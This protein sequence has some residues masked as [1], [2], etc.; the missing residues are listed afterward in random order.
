VL[1][2][3]SIYH[4]LAHRSEGMKDVLD[5]VENSDGAFSRSLAYAKTTLRDKPLV[6]CENCTKTPEEIEPGI[7]FMVCSTCKSKLKFEV[8]Y[9]SR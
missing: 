1:S 5:I 8:H 2:V 9:C 7:R 3:T 4:D 6:R